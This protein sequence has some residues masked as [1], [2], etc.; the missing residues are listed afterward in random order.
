[1]YGSYTEDF[2]QP[3]TNMAESAIVFDEYDT[4][5]EDDVDNHGF[6][7]IPEKRQKRAAFVSVGLSFI[8]MVV[9]LGTFTKQTEKLFAFEGNTSLLQKDEMFC[10]KDTRHVHVG[11]FIWSLNLVGIVLGE[12]MNRL[13]L[14]F[15][16]YFHLYTRY[17]GSKMR[18]FSACFSD[19]SFRAVFF[20]TIVAFIIICST[21]LSQGTGYFKFEYIEIILSGVGSSTLVLYLLSMDTL[22]RVQISSLMENNNRLVANGLAWSYYF[23][24]LRLILPSLGRRISESKWA[25]ILSSRKLFI[26]MPRDCWAYGKLSDEA[27]DDKIECLADGVIEINVSRA[28]IANRSYRNNIYRVK[29]DESDSPLYV[30]AEY[31]TPLC[32]MHDMSHSAEA[33]L[34]VEDRDEQA[35][36][37]VRTLEA[38]LRNPADPEARDMC[39]L[40]PYA[41]GRGVDVSRILAD[42]VLQ[43]MN[44][45]TSLDM[46]SLDG[47]NHENETSF[48]A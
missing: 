19:I 13:C 37:F 6:G 32:S 23:G 2:S 40:V 46:D 4:V 30:L 42:A 1:M 36:L 25:G 5:S 27:K 24:Y 7:P 28:G 16:E 3:E 45:N 11:I 8:I 38:I 10:K 48:N 31:A 15:E 17:N 39:V 33:N 22:S 18:M 41:R 20:A 35:K 14:V 21:L 34:T 29:I 47:V 12:F 9:L 43:D 26:M 44:G